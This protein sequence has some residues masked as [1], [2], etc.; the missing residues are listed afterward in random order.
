MHR[1]EIVAKGGMDSLRSPYGRISYICRR[2]N[3]R[4]SDRFFYPLDVW[5]HFRI[6]VRGNSND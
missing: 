3:P 1:Y 4:K 2:S 6:Q 5:S